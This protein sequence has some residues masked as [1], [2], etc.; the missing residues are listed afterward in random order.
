MSTENAQGAELTASPPRQVTRPVVTTSKNDNRKYQTIG[1]IGLALL[2]LFYTTMNN[3]PARAARALVTF[4]QTDD[5]GD[6]VPQGGS[7]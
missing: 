5:S 3:R 1:I 2:A 4:G 6:A 7:A